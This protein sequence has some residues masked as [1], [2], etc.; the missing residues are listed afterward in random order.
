MTAVPNHLTTEVQALDFAPGVLVDH[1]FA[2]GGIVL[3]DEPGA[4]I[5]IDEAA[6][7]AARDGDG[8]ADPAGPH[9]RPHARGPARRARR[10][11]ALSTGA[12]DM[13]IRPGLHRI[14]APLGERFVALYLLVGDDGGAARRHRHPRDHHRH[15]AAVPRR[16]RHRPREQVRWAIN[17][18]CDFDH[19]GGN[20]ALKAAHPARRDPRARPRPGSPRDV[21]RLIDERYGEFRD[22]D[23]F[24]DPPETTAY[25][26][27]VSDLVPV[28]R[29]AHGRRGVRPRRPLGARAARARAQPR[30]R[31][32]ARRREPRPGHRRRDARHHRA[33]RRRPAAFPP[34]YRD[35]EPYV[36]EIARVPRARRRPAAHRPLPGLRGRRR[37]RGSSTRARR[38]PRTSMPCSRACSRRSDA[39]LTTLELV[40]AAGDRARPVAARRAR[41]RDLP[42]DRQPRAAGASAASSLADGCRRPPALAV[43]G[44]NAPG[45][46]RRRRRGLVGDEQPL[47]DPRG[48]RRRRARRRVRHRARARGRARA[49]RLR[50]G[51]EDYDELLDQD[52]DAVVITTPHDLHY[53]QAVAA[54]DRGLH[55]LVEKP[56]T[57]DGRAGLGPRRAGARARACTSSRRTAG[58]TSPSRSRR[59]GSSPRATSAT[60]S[61]CSATWPRRR[62]ASS[63]A[64]RTTSARCGTP[65]TSGPDPS[66]WQS[67]APRR[68]LRPRAGHALERA[69]VLA[70]ASCAPHP[71][72]AKVSTGGAAVDLFDAAVITFDGGALGALSGAATLP[73]GD[74]TRSTSASSAPRACCCSTPSASACRCTATTERSGTSTSSRAPAPTSA[75]CRPTASSTSSPARAPRTTPTPSSPPDPSS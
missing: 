32:G 55:V 6:I 71:S 11:R 50:H 48:A 5:R 9:M 15:A 56:M 70:H 24:D 58:T 41:L 67:P 20:G 69:A 29:R 40:R 54:I 62:A 49:V 61:T 17:T 14:Q 36:A 13:E 3:G 26:R 16:G 12:I 52:L 53:P 66:T 74:R 64:T 63:R 27:S 44:V 30:A 34:T 75:S 60:S 10:R 23:G 65:K 38:T 51:D 35:V 2:D 18:H 31:R 37:R 72:M 28:D 8:W 47:P 1:E 57:L 43:V 4:G 46:A 68:R 19:T 59:S 42:R 39:R 22:T 21:Q 73:D 7:E 25:L 33:D 45:A